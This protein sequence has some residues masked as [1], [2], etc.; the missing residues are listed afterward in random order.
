MGKKMDSGYLTF[1]LMH[2]RSDMLLPAM[3]QPDVRG[4][5][6]RRLLEFGDADQRE[7]GAGQRLPD[8]LPSDGRDQLQGRREVLQEEVLLH[9]LLQP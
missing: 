7:A 5:G 6:R 3:H 1:P 9:R 2:F 4:E 8:G